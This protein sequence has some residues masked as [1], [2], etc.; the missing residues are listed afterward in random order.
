ML[1]Q[2]SLKIF[3]YFHWSRGSRWQFHTSTFRLQTCGVRR[4][5][6]HLSYPHQVDYDLENCVTSSTTPFW[7]E[8]E[9]ETA[10]EKLEIWQQVQ[11]PPFMLELAC[12]WLSPFCTFFIRLMGKRGNVLRWSKLINEIKWKR[13]S[14][15]FSLYRTRKSISWGVW[16]LTRVPQGCVLPPFP[17]RYSSCC[18]LYLLIQRKA[19]KAWTSRRSHAWDFQHKLFQERMSQV[20]VLPGLWLA[21][22]GL[23]P[24]WWATD[25]TPA[26]VRQH[27]ILSV[28]LGGLLF[29]KQKG[30]GPSIF[31]GRL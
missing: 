12:A 26:L 22:D 18:C 25:F 14:S 5:E 23:Q 10:E 1:G 6:S 27:K 30:K 20:Y 24:L 11:V 7:E 17:S 29:W 21:R 4:D 28:C 2:L 13:A 16:L 8:R 15:Q 9:E 31:Y 19:G 3:L